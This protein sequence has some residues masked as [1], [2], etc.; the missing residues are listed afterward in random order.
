MEYRKEQYKPKR[1]V[2]K[3]FTFESKGKHRYAIDLKKAGNGNPVMEIKQL[4]RKKDGSSFP[5][6]VDIWSEDF[7]AFFRA[8]GDAYRYIRSEKITTPAGHT[9]PTSPSTPNSP[10]PS[11]T[12]FRKTT[13]Q[14][15]RR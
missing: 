12:R 13:G 15:N 2:L 5:I 14:I 1:K 10:S 11:N 8:L 4:V 6:S 9:T 3:R 7:E